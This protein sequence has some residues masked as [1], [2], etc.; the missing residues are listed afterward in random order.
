MR[1]CD[2]LGE[3]DRL[4]GGGCRVAKG[5]AAAEAGQEPTSKDLPAA[6]PDLSAYV[7]AE[8][9]AGGGSLF[10][11]IR[12]PEGLLYEIEPRDGAVEAQPGP[13]VKAGR[14][15]MTTSNISPVKRTLFAK[16]APAPRQ[17]PRLGPTWPLRPLT[18]DALAGKVGT[19][20][21]RDATE[22]RMRVWYAALARGLAVSAMRR[23]HPGAGDARS[24][25]ANSGKKP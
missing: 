7:D 6:C 16:G 4:G 22:K 10:E 3:C 8:L 17:E 19:P 9:L 25:R 20:Y 11:L 18:T 5:A 12:G 21:S 24:R 1:V 13:P 15:K 14:P 2:R 23:H